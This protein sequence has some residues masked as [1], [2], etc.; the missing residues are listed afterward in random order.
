M[1]AYR[2]KS[3]TDFDKDL[4]LDI[5]ENIDDRNTYYTYRGFSDINEAQ[6]FATWWQDRWY[7]GYFGHASA[8]TDED[9]GEAI[10][11]CSRWNSCD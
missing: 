9:N 2:Y 11:L 4:E 6:R 1:V 5:L 3:S 7:F 8:I 10:V